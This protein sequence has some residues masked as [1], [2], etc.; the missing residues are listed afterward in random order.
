M[1][2]SSNHW[3]PQGP[4]LLSSRSTVNERSTQQILPAASNP[5]LLATWIRFNSQTYS[6]LFRSW[7]RL[8]SSNTRARPPSMASRVIFGQS[9]PAMN[10]SALQYQTALHCSCCLGTWTKRSRL[11]PL[12]LQKMPRQ[13]SSLR[14]NTVGMGINRSHMFE[15]WLSPLD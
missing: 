1:R 9:F 15:I 11:L 6:T 3:V 5:P 4:I 10:P 14:F 8:A 13:P 2:P 12:A 7:N